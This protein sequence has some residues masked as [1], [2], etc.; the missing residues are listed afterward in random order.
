MYAEEMDEENTERISRT[1]KVQRRVA[2]ALIRPKSASTGKQRQLLQ[3]RH[4][5]ITPDSFSE[6][7]KQDQ[8]AAKNRDRQLTNAMQNVEMYDSAI[9]NAEANVVRARQDN[10]EKEKWERMVAER[11]IDSRNRENEVIKKLKTP[12]QPSQTNKHIWLAALLGKNA[13]GY[14]LSDSNPAMIKDTPT[15]GKNT[16]DFETPEG[17]KTIYQYSDVGEAKATNRA[18]SRTLNRKQRIKERF[19]PYRAIV[20]E[21]GDAYGGP[22]EGG[23]VYETGTP[24]HTSRNFVTQRGAA[25]EADKLRTKYTRKQ[26][27]MLNMS[28]SDVYM[29]DSHD[30]AFEN[31]KY[32][33]NWADAMDFPS[34]FFQEPLD[35]DYDY[36]HFGQ[37]SKDYRVSV[38]YGKIG[39]YPKQRPHYE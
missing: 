30:G 2:S 38:G 16:P 21:L 8:S 14:A 17:P 28:P 3:K 27:S 33:D 26:R 11:L 19:A 18:N 22:S 35:E 7:I 36:S 9:P 24:V 23:W 34:T 6:S 32:T 15:R 13:V 12:R 1:S 39:D 37:P 5:V 29:M 10:P 25:K 31:L 4:D 20:H